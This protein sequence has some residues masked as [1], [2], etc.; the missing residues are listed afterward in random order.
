MSDIAMPGEDGCALVR[1]LRRTGRG[2][3]PAL[4]ITGLA[5]ESD[6]TRALA[7]GF[8]E[9]M[10]KPVDGDALVERIDALVGR[11]ARPPA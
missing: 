1:A 9:H 5:S 2:R 3:L 4:A 11:V 6:R 8:D 10:A 7:A